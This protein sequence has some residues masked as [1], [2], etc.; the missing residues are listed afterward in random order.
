[1]GFIKNLPQALKGVDLRIERVR[2]LPTLMYR[3]FVWEV[4]KRILRKTPQYS[5]RGVAHWNLSV[6][7]PNFTTYSGLGDDDNTT[8]PEWD[9]RFGGMSVESIAAHER[10]DERWMRVARNRARPIKNAIK[11]TDKVFISNGAKGDDDEVGAELYI[12]ALQNE[13]YW[14]EKLRLVNQPYEVAKESAIIVA[15]KYGKRGERGYFTSLQLRR[16]D[17][18]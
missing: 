3:D 18:E 9:A 8:Q 1:M 10:G 4:F 11:A 13:G 14:V 5:G 2:A 15:Q 6:G 7:A 16:L 12:Q 17:D